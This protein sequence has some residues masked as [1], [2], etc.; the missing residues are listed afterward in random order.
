MVTLVAEPEVKAV[1]VQVQPVQAPVNHWY[2]WVPCV[3]VK[4]YV[5]DYGQVQQPN[6]DHLLTNAFIDWL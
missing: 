2:Y 3:G 1:E 5:F 4:Y 6:V